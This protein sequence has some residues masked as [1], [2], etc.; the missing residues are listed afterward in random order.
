MNLEQHPLF[1]HRAFTVS[2]HWGLSTSNIAMNVNTSVY[3][4]QG[5]KSLTL[6]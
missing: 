5:A 2:S 3:D 6:C 4:L 1:S